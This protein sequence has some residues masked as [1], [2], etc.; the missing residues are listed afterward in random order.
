VDIRH[1]GTNG[2]INLTNSNILADTV[3]IGALGDN[4]VLTI[5]GGV[6]NA[7]TVLRL[8]AV[9][10]N[11]SVVFVSNVLL[12]GNSMKII[13][14]NAVTVNPNVIVTVGGGNPADVYVLD[15][16]KANYSDF[17][18]GN[19]TTNGRFIIQGSENSPVSGATTHLGMAPPPFDPPGG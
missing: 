11:G 6:I 7:N 14:G 15:P 19:N 5:G 16:T 18:G 13:A 2:T 8:Y 3:K 17:N 10:S 1:T 9:G 4:G 12:S